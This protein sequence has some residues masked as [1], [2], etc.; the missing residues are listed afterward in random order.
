MMSAFTTLGWPKASLHRLSRCGLLLAILA[1]PC[2]ADTLTLTSGEKLIGKV[3]SEDEASVVFVSAGL[4]K[5]VVPRDRVQRVEK[6]AA[7]AAEAAPAPGGQEPTAPA[8]PLGEVVAQI[9]P[10]Q[11]PEKKREDLLRLYWDQGLRYQFYQPITVPVPLTGG[12][13]TIGEEVR[14]SGRVGLRASFDAATFV[15]T[16]GEPDV[17]S[18]LIPRTIRIYTTGA[19]GEGP[20]RTLYAL[21]FGSVDK[22][23]YLHEGWLRW[24]GVSY[25]GNVQFGYLSV[26]QTLENVYPF[27]ALTFMEAASMSLA[28]APGNRMG[29]QFDRTFDNDRL[30]VAA[31]LWSV[32]ADPGLNFG[33]TTQSLLRPT[34]RVTGLPILEDRGRFGKRLLHLGGSL[35][36]VLA[37]ESQI[38][39]RARPESFIAPFLTDTGV[40]KARFANL[41][42]VEAIYM[43][44]PLTLQA[45]ATGSRVEG[46]PE[47]YYFHGEY[48]SA[49]W[50]LTGEQRAYDK[51]AGSLGLLKPN[52]D[53]SW[54]NNTWGAWELGLRYSHLDLNSGSVRGG[55]M[56][57]GMVGLNWYWDRYVRWQFN[58]GYAMVSEGLSPGNLQIFQARLQMMY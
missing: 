6:E 38:Q 10:E 16:G 54:K 44:G 17:D 7:A 43:D 4:G 14:I 39:Y 24:P 3:V 34:V 27:G 5:L 29:I 9:A 48:I 57:I 46:E 33:D 1:A 13:R 2:L 32:G 11:P 21:Q 42:G 55:K 49:G 26:P 56:D 22:N 23:F 40:I 58:Y 35:S 20:D 30:F 53:F 18:D 28:F 15:S 36:Y 8:A 37:K 19:F 45:E 12:E 25:V 51:A 47:R 31:G 41:A 52:T 50:F